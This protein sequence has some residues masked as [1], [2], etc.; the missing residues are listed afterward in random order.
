MIGRGSGLLL[1]A[2]A[3]L[4]GCGWM[5]DDK[6]IFVN[7]S[8]DYVDAK[9]QPALLVPEDLSG[10]GIREVMTIPPIVDQVGNETYP[11]KAPKPDSLY[12]REESQAVR[13]Q[14]LG[15]RRWLLIPQPPAVVWPKIKQFF[16]D[17][18]VELASEE[19]EAGRLDTRWLVV[20]TSTNRDVVRLV[21]R[22]GRRSAGVNAGRDRIMLR[23]EQGI[24]ERTSEI[25][26]RHENDAGRVPGSGFP[27]TSDV[28]AI[29][30]EMLNELGGYIAANV[31][32]ESVSF[33]ATGISTRTKARLTRVGSGEPA[34]LLNLDFDR[35]WAMVN[36]SLTDAQVEIVSSDREDARVDV[37]VSEANLNQEESGWF[38]SMLGRH[39]GD[40]PARVTLTVQDDQTLAVTVQSSDDH[41][42][43]AEVGERI[44]IMIREFAT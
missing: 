35:A 42:I 21:I 36:Q 19:P 1:A 26:L 15:E 2:A 33:V 3:L 27:E 18:G 31:S 34:L 38:R 16:S 30:T 25:H 44:L 20:S 13:I 11:N 14:K 43:D 22:D 6:G 17:N 9:E 32:D 28:T 12:V 40:V 5:N 24:R 41:P 29:E 4:A 10:I 7:R 8:D 23:L 37:V 39:G